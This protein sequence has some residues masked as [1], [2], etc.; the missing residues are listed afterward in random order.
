MFV[1]IRRGADRTHPVLVLARKILGAVRAD[2][3]AGLV[4]FTRREPCTPAFSF[5]PKLPL[6]GL[7]NSL[8]GVSSGLQCK[9]FPDHRPQLQQGPLV[10]VPPWR[11]RRLSS[12]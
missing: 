2:L 1:S 7:V 9:G 8:R 5:P 11:V 10:G 3:E 12:E 6:E 4:E